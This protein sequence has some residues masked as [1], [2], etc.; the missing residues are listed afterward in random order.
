MDNVKLALEMSKLVHNECKDVPHDIG[1]K[2][3][4]I[5]ASHTDTD[6]QEFAEWVNENYYNLSSIKGNFEWFNFSEN[7]PAEEKEKTTAQ[8]LEDFKVWK[9]E[10][11]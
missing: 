5:V 7:D 4:E 3:I 2:L 8:L 10:Q 11:K 9:E 1:L 6:L